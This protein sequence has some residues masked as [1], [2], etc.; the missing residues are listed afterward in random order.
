MRRNLLVLVFLALQS[1][2]GA[3]EPVKKYRLVTPKDDG[4][5]ATALNSHGDLVGFEWAEQKDQPGL[6]AQVPF[7]TKG[8]K[9]I[10]LPLLAGYTA[11]H[12][13]DIS[14]TGLVVGRVS[15]P[16]R[17]GQRVHLRNQAFVWDE[18]TGI[19][20]LGAL[21][22]DT[23]SIACGVTRD[24]TMISGFSVGENRT[25]ACVWERARDGW[26]GTALPQAGQLGSQVVVTSGN[27][28]FV[29]SIDASVPCLWSRNDAKSWVREALGEP[30]SFAPRAVNNAG[31]VVGV[32]STGD[33]L[34]H[35]V[36]WKRGVGM[37]QLEK[38]AGYERSEANAINNAGV[39]VGMID[40]PRGSAIG[41]NAFVYE[42]GRLRVLSECGPAF[43]GANAINDADQVAGIV[44]KE[45]DA[46]KADARGPE[47]ERKP[48]KQ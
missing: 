42:K 5:M 30:G 24:G 6:I 27:G 8:K 39:V 34:T 16:A 35:A 12:P 45:E 1:D 29:A 38:P 37:T 18:A 7:C 44:E 10:T 36:I 11:T 46:A 22:D 48:A 40:G 2:A 32:K 14:D 25:R 47:P 43:T 17:Q 23:A 19:R 20:G 13:A 41:P 28:R 3:D 26:N 9:L 15:K 33:A 21:K 31:V 4:I